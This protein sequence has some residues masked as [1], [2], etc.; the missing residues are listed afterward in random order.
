MAEKIETADVPSATAIN[1][2]M[3]IWAGVIGGAVFMMLEMAM[4]AIFKGSSP[5][6]PPHLIAA[7]VMGKGV[8]P[9]PPPPPGPDANVM[10]AAMAVHFTLSI[11]F[12]VII[13]WIVARL[14][15]GTALIVG[16][17]A[18]LVLYVVNFYG[19]TAVFPWF[20]MARG[21]ITIFTHVMFGLVAV[22]A[23]KALAKPRVE[24][25]IA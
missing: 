13:A 23:Y 18:G 11:I 5:W 19:F 15:M 17:V 14:D 2:P 16:A 3:A 6:G 12:G 9:S 25:R 8:V 21:W 4:V 10:M 1:W 24:P 20:A 22:G 7:I